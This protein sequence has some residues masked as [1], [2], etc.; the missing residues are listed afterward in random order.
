MKRKKRR[1]NPYKHY[2]PKV[3]FWA[4]VMVTLLAVLL[5][6]CGAADK[7]AEVSPEVP[8]P[9]VVTPAPTPT[10]EPRDEWGMTEEERVYVERVVTQE[11][12]GESY[13]GQMAVAQCVRET[14]KATGMTPYEVVIQDGQYAEPAIQTTD[15]VVEAVAEVLYGGEDAVNAPIR[16][17]YAPAICTS[18][19]HETQLAYVCEIGGHRFFM[20]KEDDDG[21]A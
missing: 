15:S 1:G 9:I 12:Q 18:E 2:L 6:T 21:K 17:F 20:E 11:A 16:Y 5:I 13:L 4:V 10:T 8:G 19:W 3:I 14:A 7:P